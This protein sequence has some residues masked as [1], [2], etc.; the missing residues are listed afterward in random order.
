MLTKDGIVK[1][2][3]FGIARTFVSGAEIMSRSLCAR[4][5]KAP[6]TIFADPKYGAAS[7][8]W[9]IGC[10]FGELILGKVVFPGTSDIDQ[11]TKISEILGPPSVTCFI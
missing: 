1:L 2:A 5:Y 11:L 9:S 8:M 3:D 10:I 7:D 6:E 4:W